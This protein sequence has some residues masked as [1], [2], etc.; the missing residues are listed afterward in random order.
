MVPHVVRTMLSEFL[1][2]VNPWRHLAVGS[3][4][5]VNHGDLALTGVGLAE[6][7]GDG[8]EGPFAP[9][10]FAVPKKR[11][12]LPHIY[13][14]FLACNWFI[15][16]LCFTRETTRTRWDL[17]LISL[18]QRSSYVQVPLGKKRTRT[19]DRTPKRITHYAMCSK[20][21][22]PKLHHKFCDNI[23]LCASDRTHVEQVER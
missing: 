22:Q 3:Q 9:L 21:G 5:L 10:W 8:R 2:V 7:D 16:R 11:V 6:A 19:A 18:L 14:D 12:S 17:L 4:L 20:C 15:C 1:H 13:I 23:E